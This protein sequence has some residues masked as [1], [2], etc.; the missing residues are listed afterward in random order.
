MAFLGGL[1]YIVEM[2]AGS[3]ER[4]KLYHLHTIYDWC[5][6]FWVCCISSLA[7]IRKDRPNIKCYT[8]EWVVQNAFFQSAIISTARLHINSMVVTACDTPDSGNQ[9]RCHRCCAST[10]GSLC[11]NVQIR[12]WRTFVAVTID[13]RAHWSH[14]HL[15]SSC[16]S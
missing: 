3:G 4:W 9:Q 8:T 13:E 1:G 12:R 15:T 16:A 7:S 2:S 14:T 5:N 6:S 11:S 10:A